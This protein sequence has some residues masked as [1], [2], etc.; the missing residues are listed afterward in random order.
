[1]PLS[2]V[3]GLLRL[4]PPPP[5]CPA[6][7]PCTTAPDLGRHHPRPRRGRPGATAAGR[8]RFTGAGRCACMR[9]WAPAKWSPRSKWRRPDRD[10]GGHPHRGHAAAD[11][12]AAAL[13]G[14]P[15]PAPISPRTTAARPPGNT[16]LA[17]V[18]RPPGARW[19]STAG[20]V[21]AAVVASRASLFSPAG[22]TG[23][24]GSFD[25]GRPG[26]PAA[27]PTARWRAG[28]VNY[29]AAEIPA[30]MGRS[31]HSGWRPG[32]RRVR[33]RGRPHRDDLGDPHLR[34][35]SLA[36]RNRGELH[37]FVVVGSA[38][39]A[40]FLVVA[41]ANNFSVLLPGAA[42]PPQDQVDLGSAQPQV[43]GTR[44]SLRLGP[45]FRVRALAR[46]P[47]LELPSPPLPGPVRRLK[48]PPNSDAPAPAAFSTCPSP[49][50]RT[51]PTL[52][53]HESW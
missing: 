25:R 21:E 14:E 4:R 52:R 6:D 33:P 9:R 44:T 11:R 49:A 31:T 16:W 8:G 1:M 3:D 53:F 40:T 38:H 17:H 45:R 42:K 5:G 7:R 30:L 18:P 51:G 10:R 34:R 19:R 43:P 12:A 32:R 2:D 23:V 29:D 20:A 37:P 46:L 26:R 47:S 48:S 24:D 22:I 41:G 35:A 36:A 50:P 15:V 13:D 28:L 39:P 27:V